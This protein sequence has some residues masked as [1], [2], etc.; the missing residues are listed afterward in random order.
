MSPSAERSSNVTG[1]YLGKNETKLSSERLVRPRN[2]NFPGS[3]ETYKEGAVLEPSESK[4][5]AAVMLE[6]QALSIE[7]G[8]D[9]D[10]REKSEIN[11]EVKRIR[12]AVAIIDSLSENENP[13]EAAQAYATQLQTR[14]DAMADYG[15]SAGEKLQFAALQR[16]LAAAQEAVGALGSIDYNFGESLQEK[17]KDPHSR[18]VT[19]IVNKEIRYFNELAKSNAAR[20]AK[21]VSVLPT[22]TTPEHEGSKAL[23]ETFTAA[24]KGATRIHTDVAAE[25]ILQF[26]DGTTKPRSGF[27]SFGDGITQNN[28]Y[29]STESFT[30]DKEQVE[31]I[32][33]EPDTTTLYRTV[34]E[35]VDRGGVF[36]RKIEQVERQEPDGETPTMV[37]NERT[38]QPEPGVKVAYQFNSNRFP[39]DGPAYDTI[40]GRPG[41]MLVVEMT[42]PQSTAESFRQVVAQD[43]RFARELAHKLVI[44]N[45]ISET[46]WS[47]T[48][49]PP[50]DQ[51]SSEWSIA[52]TDK[53]KE[54]SFHRTVAQTIVRI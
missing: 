29:H 19:F 34:T 10:F 24:A 42:L 51:L 46:D 14:V 25:T 30:T 54:G 38:G 35:S 32:I 49:R 43:P 17:I 4:T 15:V 11:A 44:E 33:F 52:I 36:K 26:K 40:S 13:Y 18:E 22:E 5:F 23:L 9:E 41:N 27:Q 53:R 1:N 47:S 37:M 28:Q 3:S 7:N 8:E 39:Y 45:G 50:Y 2:Y 12:A 16:K 20:H 48:V 21:D 31:A 6:A